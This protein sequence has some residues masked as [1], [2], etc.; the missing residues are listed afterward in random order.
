MQNA[1]KALGDWSEFALIVSVAFGLFIVSSLLHLILHAHDVPISQ[2]HLKHV[3]E[4]EAPALALLVWFMR[5]RGWTA[6]RLTHSLSSSDAL[7]GFG[8]FAAGYAAYYLAW[9]ATTAMFPELAASMATSTLV[10]GRLSLATVILV[11]LVNPVFEETFV[12]A[13]VITFLETRRGEAVAFSASVALRWLYHTYQGA[14]GVVAIIPLG[15]LFAGWYTR[16]NRLWPVII[17]HGLF[18]FFGLLQN[19]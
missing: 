3:L 7:A 2:A 5:R 6:A 16:T 13:Y 12:C 4:Y 19:A 14:R 1:I 10:S 15:L 11:S 8:L 18:D 17:A 9:M